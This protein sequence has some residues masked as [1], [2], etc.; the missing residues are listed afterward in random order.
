MT[1]PNAVVSREEA[2]RLLGAA[3]NHSPCTPI[4]LHRFK[5]LAESYISLLDQVA[6]LLK[7]KERLDSKFE[8]RR[9]SI[10]EIGDIELRE[11]GPWMLVRIGEPNFPCLTWKPVTWREAIDAAR[12][13]DPEN[14]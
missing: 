7:D 1:D 12:D 14:K 2:E 8:F 11:S 6:E 13:V 3:V 10:Y 4:S 5:A 9:K